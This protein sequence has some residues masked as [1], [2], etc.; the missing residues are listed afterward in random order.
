MV[1]RERL[2]FRKD[3]ID[4]LAPK[5]G[6]GGGSSAVDRVVSQVQRASSDL[7]KKLLTEMDGIERIQNVVV[8]GATNRP[9]L[10]DGA[11]VRPGRFDRMVYVAPP[12]ESARRDIFKIN[13]GRMVLAD[14]FDFDGL[15]DM[16]AG[17]SGAEIAH[18][19]REAA[20]AAIGES[21]DDPKVLLARRALSAQ[22]TRALLDDAIKRTT[23]RITAEML[24]FYRDFERSRRR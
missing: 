16:T 5:R 8:V 18:V 21:P 15:G 11:L 20:I 7:T 9:D 1:Q 14:G 19:C 17:F 2:T 4:A 6:S 10:L 3:E 23:P 22:I 13:L 12:E 24:R